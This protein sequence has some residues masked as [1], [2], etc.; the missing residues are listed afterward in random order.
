MMYEFEQDI[1]DPVITD[2]RRIHLNT[3]NSNSSDVIYSNKSGKI[4]LV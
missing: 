3:H 1:F 2:M 4:M